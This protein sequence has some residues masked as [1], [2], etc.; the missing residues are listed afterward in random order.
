MELINGDC[1]NILRKMESCSVDL[2]V[3]DPPY[4]IGKASWDIIDD[5]TNWLGGI[6]EE[7]C[8]VLKDNG[9]FY[10]FHNDFLQIVELQNHMKANTTFKFKQLL[11]WNKK[12]NGCKGEEF[13]QGFIEVNSLRN[14][15]KMVEYCMF[16]TKTNDVG[17]TTSNIRQNNHPTLRQYFKMILDHV[18]KS[19]SDIIRELGFEMDHPLRWKSS[20]WDKPTPK[21]YDRLVSAYNLKNWVHYKPYEWIEDLFWK[22]RYTFNNQKSHHSVLNYDIAEKQGHITPKPVE[23]LETLIKHSSNKGD[24]VLDCFMGSGST[25][26]ACKNTNREFIGIELDEEYF[27]IAKER[28]NG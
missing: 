14:Y 5:Y 6:F 11:V 8:R 1:M 3:I 17:I 21:T 4:N 25:G 20:Q 15:Q 27:N 16:Y 28:I 7:L 22:E 18:G 10:F 12:F 23:L 13:L 26:V 24:V 9:S 2:V 19:K